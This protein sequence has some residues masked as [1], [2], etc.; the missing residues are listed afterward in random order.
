MRPN[1]SITMQEG[2]QGRSSIRHGG[3]ASILG[4]KL[5]VY[6]GE[7]II[8]P[9]GWGRISGRKV[10]GLKDHGSISDLAVVSYYGPSPAAGE[11]PQW[12]CQENRLG[13]VPN[14]HRK[15]N[16]RKQ[17]FSDLKMM[18]QAWQE[19]DCN[20]IIGGDFNVNINK[21]SKERNELVKW[22]NE[23]GLVCPL[24]TRYGDTLDE[25]IDTID[26]IEDAEKVNTWH[27][28]EKEN[29]SKSF[30]DYI[31]VSKDLWNRGCVLGSAV[32]ASPIGNSDHCPTICTIDF[33]LA[34]GHGRSA[35]E[36]VDL[37][38]EFLSSLMRNIEKN[39]RARQRSFG[40]LMRSV[41]K[42]KMY[43]GKQGEERL[44]RMT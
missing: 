4:G 22:A 14:S 3:A 5:A 11:G 39:M 21:K 18:V 37:P 36:V 28:S 6:G 32:T 20:V 23:L 43:I 19:S 24:L 35:V 7:N 2:L 1:K 38:G 40:K 26:L 8:D 16:P 29:S 13:S 34:T 33:T 10:V 25:Q 30:I 9:R 17:G 41:Q 27:K 12:T 42:S 15:D 44:L 31:W